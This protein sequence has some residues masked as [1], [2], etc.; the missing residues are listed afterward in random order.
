MVAPSV[1]DPPEV[2][3]DRNQ[4][5]GRGLFIGYVAVILIS[6]PTPLSVELGNCVV[7]VKQVLR[8]LHVFVAL[9][10]I[11]LMFSF[12]ESSEGAWA[13]IRVATSC[14]RIVHV[15]PLLVQVRPCVQAYR[16]ATS[17]A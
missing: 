2:E 13:E 1:N 3:T 7:S 16:A 6:R 17:I 11:R 9:L 8:G 12:D 4:I 15:L 10:V 5:I 14:T